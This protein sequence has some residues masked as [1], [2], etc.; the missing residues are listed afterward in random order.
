MTE[1]ANRAAIRRASQQARNA[2]RELDRRAVADLLSL[3]EEAADQ[4]RAAIRAAAES[5][6]SVTLARLRPLLRQ[7]DEILDNLG[8]QRDALLVDNLQD[9]ALLGTRPYSAQGV[10]ATGRDAQAALTT[11]SVMQ[12]N[13]QAVRFVREVAAADGLRL[14]DRLWRLDQGAREVLGRAIGQAVVQGVDAAR[15]AA[16]LVYNGRPVP[17]DVAQRITG[18]K[19]NQLVRVADLLAENDDGSEVWKAERVFRTEINRAHGEAYTA[20]GENVKGFAGWRY[21]LSPQHPRPDICDLLSTQ[22]LHGLGAGVYP[23]RELTPW[24][25][26][27]NTLSFLV[28]VFEDEV[29]DADRAGKQTTLEALAKLTPEQRDGVLGKTKATYFD[30]GLLTT[31]QV[32]APLSA[33]QK[34]I[35]RL[36]T[37]PPTP[38]Q[39]TAFAQEA[40]GVAGRKVFLSLGP[41][42][43][44][45]RVQA[46]TGYNLAGYGREIDNSAVRHTLKKH[47]SVQGEASR[48]QIAVTL[49]DFGLIPQITGAPDV[50][51]ADGKNK[52]GRDVVVF[53][54]VINGVGY[55]YVEEVRTGGRVL[56]AESLRKKKGAWSA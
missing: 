48:G 46:E 35:E 3:Y 22:N 53:T 7:V 38:R 10:A 14:S 5:D 17:R 32:R 36:A 47:G 28:I 52:H 40:S 15:A 39:V 49:A 20:S 41:I 18:A 50:V 1:A 56:A 34:R 19:A 21:L 24:P 43:N 29:T 27:P 51:F 13:E 45:A 6:D 37:R 44:L 4:V 16:D 54:K 8:R 30:R 2:M 25:A 11:E 23:T 26:H 12:I 55:R 42:G 33:V 9:A 31:G